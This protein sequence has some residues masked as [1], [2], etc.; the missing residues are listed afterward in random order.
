[1]D[2]M[3]RGSFDLLKQ[4][5][6][7]MILQCIR[8]HGSIS[9]AELAKRTG[10]TP[11]SVS[12]IT[13]ELMKRGFIYE[14][15][16]GKSNG[17]RPPILLDLNA[18]AGYIIGVNLGPEFLE[19][20]VTDLE[21]EILTSVGEKLENLSKDYVL[22]ELYELIR[23]VMAKSEIE[24]D[25]FIGIGMAVH[26][27]VNNK[28]G[29]S[30]FAPHYHWENVKIKELIE[31]EFGLPVFIDNDVRAM[32]LGE[33]WFGAAQNNDNFIV[34]NISNGVGAGIVINGELYSGSS[35]SAGE[36][37]HMVVDNSGPKCSCGN[38]GCLESL[39]SDLRLINKA[40]K[41][42]K[43]GVETKIIE[44]ANNNL[45]EITVEIICQAANKG[46]ETAQHLLKEAGRYLGIAISYLLNILNP[47]L[48][49][50]VGGVIKAEDY[51]FKSI[52]EI[53]NNK[54]LKLSAKS[55]SLLSTNLAEKAAT[56]GGAT[57]VLEELFKESELLEEG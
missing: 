2:N 23:Q 27:L 6:V 17:G 24:Q 10:L 9:R 36:I 46:D 53:I 1:M 18:Q 48:V 55:V 33:S 39:V 42:I 41:L 8:K 13:K 3:I 25:D 43:Q 57:L 37:G 32:A 21:A 38:Y 29:V 50:I 7:S 4:L 49:V 51:V 14:S 56:I 15:G 30:I 45:A 5:N 11:A 20:V 47:E 40:Q 26:G 52:K 31:A 16:M 19:V 22:D 12:K 54:A 44:L 34:I 28:T 35:Y